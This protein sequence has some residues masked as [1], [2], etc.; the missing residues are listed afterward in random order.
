[1]NNANNQGL[2]KK[3][4]FDRLLVLG[5]KKEQLE[6]AWSKYKGI[7]T[8]MWEIPVF[9]WVENKQVK[10]EIEKRKSEPVNKP[11]PNNQKK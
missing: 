2:L 10:Q 5:W 11:N 1:M 8:G 3:E 6:Y 9:K 7:R 4:I